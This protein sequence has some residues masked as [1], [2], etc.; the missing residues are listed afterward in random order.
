LA[1]TF[2]S[3]RL[4]ALRERHGKSKYQVVKESGLDKA[5]YNKTEAGE[6][7][8]TDTTLQKLAPVLETSVV[9]L[10]K[11]TI[12]DSNGPEDL[13]AV[14]AW[15][16]EDDTNRGSRLTPGFW[17]SLTRDE[18]ELQVVRLYKAAGHDVRMQPPPEDGAP[19]VGDLLITKGD[20]KAVADC[21]PGQEVIDAG[22][23]WD[24]DGRRRRA[25]VPAGILL[26]SGQFHEDARDAA[27][28]LP[29][30]LVGVEELIKL[31]QETP[32]WL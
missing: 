11:L 20:F 32:P 17:K 16:V 25:G 9:E 1:A 6:R 27:A 29:I 4:I 8:P 13:R 12:E 21:S 22:Q 10:K 26:A 24:L 14:A 30:H 31:Q 3:A 28:K 18:F 23:V 2:F 7:A 5:L 19:D 15:L